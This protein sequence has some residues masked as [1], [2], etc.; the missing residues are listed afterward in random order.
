MPR[1]LHIPLSAERL[2]TRHVHW[3]SHY[4]IFQNTQ[5]NRESFRPPVGNLL[6]LIPFLFVPFLFFFCLTTSPNPNTK[7][8]DTKSDLQKTQIHYYYYYCKFISTAS[9]ISKW[10]SRNH[11]KKLQSSAHKRLFLENLE[12]PPKWA[13]KISREF[14]LGGPSPCG[15]AGLAPCRQCTVSFFLAV[16]LFLFS[17]NLFAHVSKSKPQNPRYKN[18]P[19][20]NKHKYI[21]VNSSAQRAKYQSGKVEITKKVAKFRS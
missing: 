3:V 15:K 21:F 20:K 14:P 4:F 7:I 13:E 17:L 10:Q 19:P 6:F 12:Q 16:S 8:Q 2:T 1:L 11:K 18:R 5:K 9:K